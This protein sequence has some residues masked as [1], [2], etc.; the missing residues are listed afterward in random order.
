MKSDLLDRDH[1]IFGDAVRAF[2]GKFVVPNLE[3]WDEQRLIDR[4]TWVAAGKQAVLGLAMPGPYGGP[5]EIDYRYRFAI[6]SE[7][8]RVGASALQSGF[9]TNDDIVLN[10]LLRHANDEQRE[11]WLPG[12]AT[13]ETIGAIATTEPN[14][15][16]DLRAIATT[17]RHDGDEWVING[18]KTFITNGIQADLVIVFAETGIDT[19]STGFSLF[20]IEDGTP[21]FTRGRKLNKIGLHVQDTAELSF[22]DVRVPAANL[23]GEVGAGFSNLMQSLPLERLGIG[24][25]AQT[26]AEA[27]FDW[28]LAYVKE[29]TA[30]GKPIGS[31]QGLGFTLAE[32]TTAIE[33]CRAYIDQCV[34]AYNVGTLTAID[35]AKAKR[36]ATRHAR[37]CRR[38]RRPTPRRIRLH[39][40]IPRRQGLHRRPHPTDLRRNQRIH[41]GNHPS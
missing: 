14:A 12:F 40:G 21:G 10:Y 23:L 13:G 38:C 25:A 30:F 20:V 26:S 22:E 28:T 31:F 6:H 4:G 11:L 27:V 16:S 17:S 8:A 19:S 32:L 5:G 33:V 24:V 41:E 1:E 39:V 9:S 37:A 36:W 2:V 3:R 18:Q 15:G 35:A 29:R 34:R 7:L